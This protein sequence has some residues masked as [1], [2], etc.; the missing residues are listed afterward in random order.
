MIKA[1]DERLKNAVQP[2]IMNTRM[3]KERDCA[4]ARIG[5]DVVSKNVLHATRMSSRANSHLTYK[6]VNDDIFDIHFS[7][8]LFYVAYIWWMKKIVLLLFKIYK[9]L[10]FHNI[11]TNE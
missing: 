5:F 1:P 10:G 8:S 9:E 4:P 11:C 2:A 6:I 7:R 3:A